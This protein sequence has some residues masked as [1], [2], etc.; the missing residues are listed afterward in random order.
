[1]YPNQ[2]SRPYRSVVPQAVAALRSA[3]QAAF[4]AQL[5][6]GGEKVYVRGSS[7]IAEESGGAWAQDLAIAW[8][9]FYPGYQ[10]PTRALSEELGEAV[11]SGRNE[12]SGWGPSQ[13]E[14][15]SI[16]CAS[17]CQYGGEPNDSNWDA[18]RGR[19]YG[20]IATGAAGI[21]DPQVGGLY[22]G[23]VVQQVTI[24]AETSLHQVVGRRGILA[25]VTF[26]LECMSVS[27]M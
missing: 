2:L 7:W 5:A 19:V 16:G 9:G 1:V 27:Q 13:N 22:L 3:F 11:V 23:D 8:Y 15:F 6:A 18:I 26:N 21:S 20:N 17:M 4:A 12:L 10:Y 24:G 25:I 14:A